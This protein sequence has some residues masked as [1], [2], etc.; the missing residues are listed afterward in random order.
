MAPDNF[1]QAWQAHSSR[2]R[3]T[4]DA[5]LLLKE[6]QHSQHAFRTM[7]FWRD[8]REVVVSLLMI[9]L[10]FYLGFTLSLP[11]TWYLTVPAFLWVTGF[12]L[13]DRMC[14]PPQSSES[15]EPLLHSLKES[16]TQVEHQIWLLRNVFWWYLLPFTIS[17]L[18]FFAHVAWQTS[19]WWIALGNT[20]FVA[21][22]YTGIYFLNQRCVRLQLEPRR[23]ELLALLKNLGEET[24]GGEAATIRNTAGV[25]KSGMLW[26]WLVIVILCSVALVLIAWASGLFDVTYDGSPRSSGPAGASL[27]ELIT[28][29]RQQKKLVGLAAMVTVDGQVMASAADGER[30]KGSGIAIE[31]GDRWHLGGVAKS[32]TATMI[33]RLIQSGQMKWSDT[34]SERF[35][36]ASIHVD[37]RPVT[38]KQLLTDTAGAPANFPLQVLRKHPPLGPECTQQRRDAVMNVIAEKPAYPP[39]RKFAYSNV[40]CTIAVAMAE[41]A[42]AMNWEDLVRREVFEPL[43]LA[44]AGFGPP[45]S[46]SA[47]LDQ[48]RGHRVVEGWKISANDDSDNTLIMGPSGAVHMTL[49]DLC[50]Y[51]AEHLR[52]ER[53]E[54][55]LLPPET[56]KLLHTPERDGYAY[57]WLEKQPTY[58]VPHTLYWHNGSNTMW[59]ALVVFIPGK[60][61]VVA[62]TSND[63]DVGQAESAAWK[64]V[65]ASA[66][67]FDVESDATRRKSLPSNAFPK[68]SPFN[69]V[70]WQDSQP[71]VR[72]GEEWFQLVSLDG[73]TVD[74]I[75]TFCQRTYAEKWQKR[76]AEDLVEVL[77]RMGHEPK[78]AVRLVVRPVGASST[79][80]LE[81]V[82]MTEANRRAIRAAAAP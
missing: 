16:L 56:Y 35:P 37:W 62:V 48:P 25:K 78:D 79:Q 72:V 67:Q 68:T 75:L 41:A 81:V 7:I 14:H 6:I 19:N 43:K 36:N 24:S 33:A 2:T 29:L 42:T 64:I 34:I 69:A 47:T 77:V 31:L 58:E 3:V 9:P 11:W 30:K 12:I 45:K 20:L 18:A 80:T 17:I 65:E 1:Q 5:D 61:M 4:V 8:F 66:K 26:R 59:Y 52:G 50:I 21:A 57:G 76:F 32:I 63:G 28:D 38:L 51:A 15:G 60:N 74:D 49:S 22:L 71:E 40:G 70:R 39:G 27:A 23:Q 82:P 46:P 54:G 53:G 10:W 73:I 55:T 44:S 13:V